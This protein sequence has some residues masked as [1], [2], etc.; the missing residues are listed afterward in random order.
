MLHIPYCY[1]EDLYHLDRDELDHQIMVINVFKELKRAYP[2]V[3]KGKRMCVEEGE[4]S[5]PSGRNGFPHEAIRIASGH[6]EEQT[7]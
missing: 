2:E 7:K 1:T 4:C 5:L 6:L 3:E